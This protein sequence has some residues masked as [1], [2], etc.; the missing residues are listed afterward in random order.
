MMMINCTSAMSGTINAK[1]IEANTEE[2][3]KKD[4]HAIR[5]GDRLLNYDCTFTVFTSR[6]H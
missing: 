5:V 3:S 2:V 4:E 6:L 1:K